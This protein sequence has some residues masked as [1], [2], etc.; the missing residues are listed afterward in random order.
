M[1]KIAETNRVLVA[2]G[3]ADHRGLIVKALTE[4]GH[5]VTETSRGREALD[6]LKKHVFQLVITD[7]KLEGTEGSDI[8]QS[9]QEQCP[10]TPVIMTVERG[11]QDD[12]IKAMMKGAFEFRELP[13]NLEH[14]RL[15]VHRALEKASLH[16]AFYYLRHEQPYLYRLESIVAESPAMKE[17]LNQVA[18]L[19]PTNSTVL[20]TGETGVGKNLI[21]GAV[22]ANSPRREATIVTVS[23]TT[24]AENLLESELFGHEKGAFTGAVQPRTGRFQQAHGGT[25]FLDEVGEISPQIQAKLLRA[26]ED[27]LIY[28]LGGS[29][30]I[31]VNVRI[32]AATNR[33]LSEDVKKGQFR[34]DFFYRLNVAPLFIPPLRERKEDIMPLVERFTRA[35]C[36]QMSKPE[37][38]YLPEAQQML[39]EHPWMGNVRELR[40]VV[41]RTVLFTKK[42]QVGLKE[43]M[44]G[45]KTGDEASYALPGPG[46]AI[47]GAFVAQSLNLVEL[48]KQAIMTALDQ[49]DWVQTK[50]ADLLGVTPSSLSY[51][52]NRLGIKDSRFRSRRR[53]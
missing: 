24:L 11:A 7:L 46:S 18:H 3:N 19:A 32:I 20:I 36:K 34:R 42:K 48:E 1:V 12:G 9:V 2:V 21:A 41:E 33:D 37:L 50:A 15:T 5:K 16:H 28:R 13:L 14:L 30:E 40:N 29:R 4:D 47:S 39:V 31:H 52:L 49:T 8:V 35:L 17:V 38:E 25:L 43:L 45:I 51:K 23:C 44:L 10:V 26:I 27:Q 22:H 53:R 6:L